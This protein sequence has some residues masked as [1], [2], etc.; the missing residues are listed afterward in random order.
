[1]SVF[2]ARNVLDSLFCKLLPST[3]PLIGDSQVC[4]VQLAASHASMMRGSMGRCL[5]KLGADSSSPA[6]RTSPCSLRS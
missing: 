2:P 6:G 1:M 3:F 5:R 4:Y